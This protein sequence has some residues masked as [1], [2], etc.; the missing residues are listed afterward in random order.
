MKKKIAAFVLLLL[1]MALIPAVI[2][3]REKPQLKAENGASADNN[4]PEIVALA[5]SMCSDDFC[6]EAVRAMVILAN[7]DYQSVEPVNNNSDK[8]IINLASLYYDS[9]KELYIQKN[10]KKYTIPYSVLSN[11]STAADVDYPY[12]YPSASPWD[13]LDSGFDENSSCVGVSLRGVDYLCK[14][15]FSAEQALLHYL[16]GFEICA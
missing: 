5:A 14:H 16:S 2:V 11:G 15:G 10:G 4:K 1:V 3:C 12:L 6:D 13:C 9:N 8:E 7:T